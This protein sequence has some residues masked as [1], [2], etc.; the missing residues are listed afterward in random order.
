MEELYT[1]IIDEQPEKGEKIPARDGFISKKSPESF[2]AKYGKPPSLKT[3]DI[4]ARQG[5]LQLPSRI[6]TTKKSFYENAVEYAQITHEKTEHIPFACYWPSYEYMSEPQINWYFYLR[7]R[8]REGEYINT[9]LSYLFV[10]IYE[11]IN[12]IGVKNPDDGFEKIVMLWKNYRKTH[13]KL[14]RYLIDWTSDYI[15]YYKC[16]A[17]KT[18]GLLERENLFLLM[19]ADML[20]EHYIKNNTAMP[21]ELIT[22]FCD[23]KFYESEFIKSENGS[24]FT[25]NLPGLFNEIRE[26]MAKEKEGGF[27]T[28]FAP[29][30]IRKQN[31]MPFL[32]APFEN[33]ENV[34]LQSYFFYEQHKPLRDFFTAVVKEF[35]NRLRILKKYKGRLRPEKLPDEILNICQKYAK[36][37][38]ENKKPEQ[39]VEIIIDREKLL[40]LIRDSDEVRK[41]LLEGNYE[42]GE[43]SVKIPQ[44][45]EP[46]AKIPQSADNKLLPGLP[47]VRQNILNF[48]SEKGGS[49][50][51]NEIEE[52]FKGIFIGVEI[53]K[54][55]ESALET[56]G[57]LIIGFEDDRWY[58]IEDYIEDL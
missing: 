9:D 37:A 26:Q 41:K 23:Y 3:K 8:L 29:P 58:I 11:L 56:I 47:E 32:R 43:E 25:D 22:R 21:I 38:A 18:F 50:K 42:Y 2:Y 33:K 19:P 7:S 15:K 27:E 53:D 24:L 49:C 12:Q 34:R 45:T 48:L 40:D 5:S 4:I 55:N 44:K 31:K 46:S 30:E 1:I 16:E 10:Y 13:E 35:E 36:N 17:E 14:D 39:C 51:S 6:G 52:A 57:D 20:M 28:R 54:I